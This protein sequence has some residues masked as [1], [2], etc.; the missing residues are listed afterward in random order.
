MTAL[1][2]IAVFLVFVALVGGYYYLQFMDVEILPENFNYRDDFTTLDRDFWYVG[3][4]QTTFKA[5]DKVDLKNGIL[6]AEIT[7]TDR[8]PFLL[9]KPLPLEEG[10]VVTI[11][12]RVKLHYENDRFTGG[13]AIVQT[14][15]KDLKPFVLDGN[16]GRSLGDGVAL[17]EYVHNFDEESERPGRDVFRVLSPT[18]DT[19]ASYGILEPVFDDWFEE[20]LVYDTRSNKISYAL[21]GKE[22][23]INGSPISREN[24]RVFMHGYGWY[25]GHY[26]KVDWFEIT[27]EN[28]R[29]E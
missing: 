28:E 23:V 25:T 9:S 2:R 12:R 13:L 8:G 22:V 18:W 21:N 17:V 26:M 29:L 16:W 3:E 20:E 24:I 1:R 10:D 11:K 7:E 27:I 6:T 14:S 5:Y 19:D 15:D 4:W